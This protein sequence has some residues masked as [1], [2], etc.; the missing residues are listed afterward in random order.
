[1]EESREKQGLSGDNSRCDGREGKE[2]TSCEL[3]EERQTPVEE[4]ERRNFEGEIK[5]EWVNGYRETGKPYDVD[6]EV[7]MQG[8]NGGQIKSIVIE[9]LFM[10]IKAT[11]LVRLRGRSRYAPCMCIS[12]YTSR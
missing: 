1:M 8:T 5:A 12:L 7:R 4:K 6:I 11:V 3:R 10:E 9:K 2:G